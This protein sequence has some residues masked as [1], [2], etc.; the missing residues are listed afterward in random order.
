M[1]HEVAFEQRFNRLGAQGAS[2]LLSIAA[3]S[4]LIPTT[5]KLLGQTK[6]ENLVKQSRGV[7]IVL[8]FVYT[9]YTFCQM[10]THRNEYY[11]APLAHDAILQGL[12]TTLP[13]ATAAAGNH[14]IS[15]PGD[16]NLFQAPVY[17][18]R[19]GR[20]THDKN[21][22]KGPQL[23]FPVAILVFLVSIVLLYLCID[24]TID[25]IEALTE[26]TSLTPMFIGLILLPI[27]NLDFAPISLAVDNYLEQTMRYTVGR[28]IQTALL[29]EPLVVLLAWW[30]G[31]AEVTLA[32][33]G[34]EVVSLFTTIMLLALDGEMRFGPGDVASTVVCVGKL[35]PPP[36]KILLESET[37]LVLLDNPSWA[38]SGS[39]VGP[40]LR[41]LCVSSIMERLPSGP[42]VLFLRLGLLSSSSSPSEE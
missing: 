20:Q 42:V 6:D 5:V 37:L 35:W 15:A 34:F 7:A 31:V 17:A 8:L 36:S 10:V 19:A 29:V 22:I 12:A 25:S 21:E 33:D 13:M 4:I 9:A 23:C 26:Q 11:H 39:G 30:T 27:P 41:R 32:L 3:T 1:L 18:S 24:A 16:P 28:S 40:Y 38:V 2:T 14:Q